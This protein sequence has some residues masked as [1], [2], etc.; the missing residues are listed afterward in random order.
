M[1]ICQLKQDPLIWGSGASYQVLGME[2]R[3]LSR[4]KCGLCIEELGH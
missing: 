1:D 2:N 3:E 4:L